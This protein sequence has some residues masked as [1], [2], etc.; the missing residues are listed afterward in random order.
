VRR[1]PRLDPAGV[2]RAI[3]ALIGG[4]GVI[5]VLA[6]SNLKGE[7]IPNLVAVVAFGIVL[8]YR[9]RYPLAVVVAA[10]AIASIQAFAL[11]SVNDLFTPF[12][13]L[14]FISYAAGAHARRGHAL[15]ALPVLAAAVTLVNIGQDSMSFGDFFF[16]SSFF[17]VCWLTGRAVHA[18]TLLTA[19]LHEAA[20]RAQEA[21]AE[22]AH[23]AMAEERRRIAREM[24][25]V[26]AH[27]V[28]VMVIQAGGARRIIGR[29]PDRAAVAA[30]LIE[31]TGRAA[32]VEM[33]RLLG[34][35]GTGEPDASRAPQPTLANLEQLVAGA[36]V[37]VELRVVGE[38]RPLPAGLDLAAYR[39]VQE[40][41]TNVLK[42][43]GGAATEVTVR[44]GEDELE[45]TIADRGPGPA[46][47]RSEGHGLVGMEERVRLYG[48]VLQTGPREG[49]GF[50]V[51]ARLPLAR[52][53]VPA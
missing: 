31:K 15:L 43:A 22:E 50:E 35:L 24:H 40:A 47:A 12:L 27:S 18:R 51:R 17:V 36:P 25:D 45:L 10:C 37:P 21:H 2:D 44:W 38:R 29:D 8:L 32:L 48:G 11:A 4:L 20:V 33:R 53:E 16:P 19:E 26:V 49:G 28:S 13:V 52:E 46:A 6:A 7:L 30:A 14:L 1:L 23:R 34:L 42:H 3:A 39:I 9:R 41:L 5:E